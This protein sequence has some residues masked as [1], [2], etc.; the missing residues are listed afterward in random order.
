MPHRNK[1][2]HLASWMIVVICC[3]M[4]GC[5]SFDEPAGEGD[6]PDAA[7]ISIADLHSMVAGRR[8]VINEDITIG[9]YVTTSDEASNFYRTF[10]IEDA[11]G[12]TEVMAGLYDL[13]N[14]YPKG[15]Y[16]TVS[17][18][19]CA[20]GESLGVMQ[21]GMPAEDYSYYPTDYFSSRVVMDKHVKRYNLRRDIAPTPLAIRDLSMDYCGRL[22]NIAGLTPTQEGV[23][24]GYTIF[25]DK[26]GQYIAVYTSEYADYA[27]NSLPTGSVSITGIL[28][29]GKVDGEEYYII[30]MRDEKDCSSN[31]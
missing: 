6:N 12:G 21:I 7:N 27:Q 29:Y 28:Q 11:S 25:T 16:L 3:S 9:G 10:I 19:G 23:W 15:Y 1:I 2:L 14:I 24:A 20:V 18:K 17:L 22:V 13:H 31:N 30:K 8:V 26:N 4:M 5:K